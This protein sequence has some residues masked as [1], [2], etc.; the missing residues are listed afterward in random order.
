MIACLL[1]PAFKDF[2]YIF[3]KKSYYINTMDMEIEREEGEMSDTE[4]VAE[5]VA[6][7]NEDQNTLPLNGLMTTHV[8]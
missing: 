7:K 3:E 4:M 2:Y 5:D 8:I 6:V 1:L